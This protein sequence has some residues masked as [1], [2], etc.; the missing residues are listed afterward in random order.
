MNKFVGKYV[1]V[2]VFVVFV[3]SVQ[4]VGVVGNL[5]DGVSKVVMCIGCYGIQDYCVVYLEVYWVFVF[6]GQNQ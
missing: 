5:K 2:V 4:V 6:G 3:G 1:V